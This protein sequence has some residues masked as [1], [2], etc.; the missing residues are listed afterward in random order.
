MHSPQP[1]RK[2]NRRAVF[3][4]ASS[5]G[6]ILINKDNIKP[7]IIKD[8]EKNPI[9]TL[10]ADFEVLMQ[11]FPGFPKSMMK[12]LLLRE[13]GNAQRIY[14]TLQKKGWGT[15]TA[16][17]HNLSTSSPLFLN[18]FW[19][20]QKPEY[21]EYIKQKP[22]GSYYTAVEDDVFIVC[23]MANSPSGVCFT[24]RAL[25]TPKVSSTQENLLSLT[26]PIVRPN[27]ISLDDILYFL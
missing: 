22:V 18:Y 23:F 19:G 6:K 7:R 1:P 8:K 5:F 17:L 2:V 20:K 4:K 11:S 3:K 14:K 12:T 24:E 9:I 13:E 10:T 27:T 15:S 25:V 21:K 26:Q 16:T